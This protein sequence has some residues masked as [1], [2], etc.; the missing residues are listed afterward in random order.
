V[1]VL[2]GA[3]LLACRD[4][5]PENIVLEGGQWGGRVYL[6]D[7]GG[8]QGSSAVGACCWTV[9]GRMAVAL[10]RLVAGLGA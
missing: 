1:V 8:V 7:F 3:L 5:K 4:I 2:V 9:G 10:P 6:I